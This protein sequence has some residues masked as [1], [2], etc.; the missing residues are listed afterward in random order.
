MEEIL[1]NNGFVVSSA[2]TDTP[3]VIRCLI[4]YVDGHEV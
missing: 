2:I 3:S 4:A 1:Q